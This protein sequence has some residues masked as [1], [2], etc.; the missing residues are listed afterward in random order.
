MRQSNRLFRIL[1]HPE[2]YR[3]T[4][5]RRLVTRFKLGPYPERLRFGAAAYPWYGWCLYHAALQARAL[6][7]G[8][9][10]AIE[11]G[12][13]GGAG[14]LALRDHA[15][16]VERQTGVKTV[17]FGLDAG[18]GL[19]ASSDYR[20][21]LYCWPRGSFPMDFDKLRAQ[22]NGGA[23]LVIGNI[24]ETLPR[25]VWPADAP[26]AVVL[27][28]LDLYSSTVAALKVLAK[29]NR[30]ARVWCWLDD[31]SGYP[32]NLYSD[33]TGVRLAVR[34]YNDARRDGTL[35]PANCFKD[36][37]PQWW[38]DL[39]YVDHDFAHPAYNR[40]LSSEIHRLDLTR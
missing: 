22:L 34:E 9:V 28:D 7:F 6:D 10:T 24:G 17:I 8:R 38:H 2:P 13:A 36:M 5:A 30:L 40:C 21:L 25:L 4:L 18:S 32:D 12:V 39:V 1:L 20:D 35:S 37:R 27:F 11:M 3:V 15:V 31:I 19:P 23:E 26:L 29:P 33:K 14:L 16:E